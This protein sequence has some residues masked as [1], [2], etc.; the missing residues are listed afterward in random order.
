[1]FVR[2][3]RVR[4][5][6]Y[7]Q[8]VESVRAEA[9]PRQRVL[10]TLGRVEE[11]QAKGSIDALVSSLSKFSSNA[12]ALIAGESTPERENRTPVNIAN[13]SYLDNGAWVAVRRSAVPHA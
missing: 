12:L 7:L 10:A 5:Y 2:L 11:L 6:R 3:K 4:S 1:M 8:L 13:G 9:K